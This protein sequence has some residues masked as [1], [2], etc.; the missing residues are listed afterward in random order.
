[1]WRASRA[2]AGSSW[3]G[4]AA[5]PARALRVPS[6]WAL[7]QPYSA[8]GSTSGLRP[9]PDTSSG[10]WLAA[11]AYAAPIMIG[12]SNPLHLLIAGFALY[13]AWKLNRG[14]AIRITGPYQVGAPRSAAA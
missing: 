13:E 8:P 1:M 12:I 5:R 2:A 3:S 14:V 6:A 9:S 10:S 7:A 11:L 4:T